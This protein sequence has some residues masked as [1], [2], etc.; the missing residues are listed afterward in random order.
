MKN[1]N[2][3]KALIKKEC[4]G[5]FTEQCSI[6]NYCPS[7]DRA[8]LF[9]EDN[10]GLPRCQYFEEGVLPLEEDLEKD[11]YEEREIHL[12]SNRKAK[13]KVKCKRC[14]DVFDANSNR[15]L[16]CEKCKKIIKREQARVSMEKKRNKSA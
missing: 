14:G 5:Y 10:N 7:K 2:K 11:Y 1:I 6:K 16:Y 4:A 12:I 8:C 13:P 3:I 9:F 15:Q